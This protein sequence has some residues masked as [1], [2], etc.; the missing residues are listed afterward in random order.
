M[1]ESTKCLGMVLWNG[2]VFWYGGVAWHSMVECR[3]VASPCYYMVLLSLVSYF[4][5]DLVGPD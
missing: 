3:H 1:L 4:G 2:M 5:G